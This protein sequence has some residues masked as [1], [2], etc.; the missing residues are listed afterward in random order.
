[1]FQ[2]LKVCASTW[3]GG[4][5][6]LEVMPRQVVQKQQQKKL[7]MKPIEESNSKEHVEEDMSGNH[8][9]QTAELQNQ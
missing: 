5:F 4:S 8:H 9:E 2:I 1:V 3:N 7:N 6:I